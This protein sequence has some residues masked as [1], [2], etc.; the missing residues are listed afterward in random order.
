MT[1][2]VC[3]EPAPGGLSRMRVEELTLAPGEE[4]MQPLGLPEETFYYLV[5][6]YGMLTSDVYGYA[7]EPQT[8]V[9]IPAKTG[10]AICN[11]GG[12]ECLIVRYG[13]G[14]ATAPAR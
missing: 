13:F 4:S 2:R 12:V 11:T 9:Y 10:H 14:P 6:G 8:G 1:K 7:L 3:A 5:S